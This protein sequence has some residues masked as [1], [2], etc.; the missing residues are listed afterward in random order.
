MKQM[1][2]IAVL[3]LIGVSQSG[4]LLVAAAAGTGATVAYVK[5]DVESTLDSTPDKVT[6][7]SKSALE[8]MELRVIASSSSKVDGDV[9]ARTAGDAKVH[10]VVKS[11]GEK[12]SHISIRVGVFGD[13]SMSNRILM[14]INEKLAAGPSTQ[15]VG[16]E[17]PAVTTNLSEEVRN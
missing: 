17:P 16:N 8:E 1:L 5:G 13:Q 3:G 6:E 14:K 2:L 11:Q 4:C 10:I 7:A 12:T 9:V 15:P